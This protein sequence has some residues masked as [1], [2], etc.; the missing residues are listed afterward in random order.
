MKKKVFTLLLA[1][2]LIGTVSAINLDLQIEP[3]KAEFTD[4]EDVVLDVNVTSYEVFN[5]SENTVLKSVFEDGWPCYVFDNFD[6]VR[7]RTA[8]QA[9]T[10]V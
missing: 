4:E 6:D 10:V 9:I 2:L 5:E 1:I 3:Q 8:V 7:E